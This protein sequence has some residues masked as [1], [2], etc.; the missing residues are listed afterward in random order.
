MDVIKGKISDILIRWQKS[1][2]PKIK[3]SLVM[4]NCDPQDGF[5]FHT[6]DTF[7]YHLTLGLGVK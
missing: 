1:L 6:Q 2:S 4:P 5:F 3:A 7:F